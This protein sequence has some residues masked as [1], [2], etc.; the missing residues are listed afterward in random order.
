VVFADE[1]EVDHWWQAAEIIG[2]TDRSLRRWKRRYE[3]HGFDGLFDRRRKPSP[4]QVPMAQAEEALP[5]A[6]YEETVPHS[7]KP[8]MQERFTVSGDPRIEPW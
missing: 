8:V 2:I 6:A 4:K 3:K 7:S 1:G 5:L